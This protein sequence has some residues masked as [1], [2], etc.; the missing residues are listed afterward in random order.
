[1]SVRC[2]EKLFSAQESSVHNDCKHSRQNNSEVY[3][4]G[5]DVNAKFFISFRNSF[6]V[7]I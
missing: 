5:S 1:M 6:E 7:S 3:K 2:A 4:D